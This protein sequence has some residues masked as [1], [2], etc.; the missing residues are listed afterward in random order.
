MKIILLFNTLFSFMC[1]ED[2]RIHMRYIN[3]SKAS[4]KNCYKCLRACPVKAI[5]FTENQAHIDEEKCIACG[6]CLEICPQGAREIVSDLERIKLQIKKE[7]KVVVSLAPSFSGYLN[8]SEGKVCA[9]LKKLGFFKVEETAVG[10]EITLKKYKEY[11]RRDFQQNYITSCCPSVNYLIEK[12]FPSLLK[13]LMPVVSPMIAHGKLLKRTY[14]CDSFVVFIGPCVGKKIEVE[15]NVEKNSIDAVIT[16]DELLKWFARNNINLES[17]EEIEFDCSSAE[18]GKLFPTDKGIINSLKDIISIKSMQAISVNGINECINLFTSMENNDLNNVFVE[19]NICT[20]N[21]I[22]GPK[23]VTNDFDYYKRVQ[24]VNEYINAKSSI[25][26]SES[27]SEYIH[28]DLM[29]EFTNKSPIKK[30]FTDDDIKEIM[31]EMGKFTEEDELNCGVCGYNTCRD[32]AEAI[33]LGMAEKEMCM[34]FMRTK[35]ES[36]SSV[37]FEHTANSVIIVDNNL[38]IKELNPAA[39][40]AFK[41]DIDEVR[42]LPLCMLIDDE[43]FQKVIKNKKNIIGKRVSYPNYNAVFI[44]NIIYL[45]EENLILSTLLDITE[46]EKNKKELQEVRGKALDAAQDVIEKQMR[47]AQEIAGLLGETTAETKVTLNRLSRIVA[48]EK[49]DLI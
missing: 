1:L 48:G 43:D 3:F 16:F 6:R 45:E 12:Y 4:C 37:I 34:H 31:R 13:F 27:N 26:D 46:E 20:G 36:R 17:L 19:A 15:E 33:L 25:K 32:K 5:R 30:K 9:A 42:N 11:I 21:C 18:Q 2:R 41:T 10:A 40:K 39:E 24:K 47:V 38:N 8:L 23:M 49:D 14:G 29:K 44:I 28:I 7:R 35:A 22:G